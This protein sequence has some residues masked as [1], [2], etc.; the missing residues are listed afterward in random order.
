MSSSDR[1]S[2]FWKVYFAIMVLINVAEKAVQ[3]SIRH[4]HT[5]TLEGLRELGFVQ[6]AAVVA[7]DGLKEVPK[8][9]LGLAAELDELVICYLPVVIDVAC[10]E[11]IADEAICIFER[12]TSISSSVYV[13]DVV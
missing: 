5:G 2:P 13:S 1:T 12:C 9:L 7:V 3:A 10:R 4:G 6:I 11:H 8:L